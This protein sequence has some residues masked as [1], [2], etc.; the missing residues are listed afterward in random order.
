VQAFREE[1]KKFTPVVL[2]LFAIYVETQSLLSEP[3]YPLYTPDQ[4]H[5]LLSSAN[6]VLGLVAVGENSDEGYRYDFVFDSGSRLIF[7]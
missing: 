6:G 7:P 1:K 2:A 4:S 5:R 3:T